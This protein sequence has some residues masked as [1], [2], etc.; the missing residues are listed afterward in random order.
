MLSSSWS[1]RLFEPRVLQMGQD[2][3]RR[4]PVARRDSTVSSAPARLG[5]HGTTAIG[6][7]EMRHV[8][9]Q[10]EAHARIEVPVQRCRLA[11]DARSNEVVKLTSNNRDGLAA[12]ARWVIDPARP[13]ALQR[14]V[15]Q[16]RDAEPLALVTG[17]NFIVELLGS[18]EAGTADRCSLHVPQAIDQAIV[19]R[20]MD[21]CE[22]ASRAV[23]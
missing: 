16:S 11:V 12:P 4:V 9:H 23:A 6:W 20:E 17:P 13:V 10:R 1:R 14:V 2:A 18:A 3:A 22:G 5:A 7:D 15:D 19:R 8:W 21:R